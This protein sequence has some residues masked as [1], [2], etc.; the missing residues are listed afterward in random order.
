M[1]PWVIAAFLALVAF[2]MVAKLLPNKTRQRGSKGRISE[3]RYQSSGL[4]FSGQGDGVESVEPDLR[5]R[6]ARTQEKDGTIAAIKELKE[7]TGWGLKESKDF[8]D[9]LEREEPSPD[10]SRHQADFETSKAAS[11]LGL[12][13]LD[14]EGFER[15]M[16]EIRRG[17]KISAIKELRAMTGLG[18]RESKDLVEEIE[19]LGLHE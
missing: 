10:Y 7:A 16:V 11:G 17:R 8:V 9:A 5:R 18:L 19:R 13:E 14:P 4:G 1:W 12:D 2:V 15:V 6:I 3:V